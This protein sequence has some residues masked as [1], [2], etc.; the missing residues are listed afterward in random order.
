MI[1]GV[2]VY[3]TGDTHGKFDKIKSFSNRLDLSSDDVIVILGDAGLNFFLDVRDTY[4]KK[5][6]SKLKPT[7]FCIH[8][9]HE[10]RPHRI[11]TYKT[12]EFMGGTVW[13]EEEYPNIVFAKDGEIY[14]MP[15]KNGT[16]HRVLVIGGAYSVDKYYR[17]SRGGIW[18]SDEQPSAEIKAEVESV[19]AQ[20]NWEIDDIFT[21]T[22]PLIF[23]PIEWFISGLD[24]SVVDKSTEIWLQSILERL[25][26]FGRWYFAHYHGDKIIDNKIYILFNTFEML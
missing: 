14:N 4:G 8:G 9:N 10:C 25:N 2:A 26:W 13:Y 11:S 5:K 18:F 1:L 24:Q 15:S 20:N 16:I 6:L 12:K 3:I 17:L 23:E 7:I 19:L 22:A 21:H